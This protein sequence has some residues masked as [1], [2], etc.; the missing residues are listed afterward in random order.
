MRKMHSRGV[1]AAQNELKMF[2]AI[3]KITQQLGSGEIS[4][5]NFGAKFWTH[6]VNSQTVSFHRCEVTNLPVCP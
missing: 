2:A 6:Q 5:G 3:S 4:T 1:N